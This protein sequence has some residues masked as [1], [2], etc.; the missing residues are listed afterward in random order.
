MKL[1][2]LLFIC[3]SYIFYIECTLGRPGSVSTQELTMYIKKALRQRGSDC[4]LSY[5]KTIKLD[6][7]GLHKYIEAIFYKFSNPNAPFE[8]TIRTTEKKNIMQFYFFCPWF[9]KFDV[10]I[11]KY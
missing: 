3:I 8:C 5:M 4:D 10:T 2:L 11:T 9:N 7:T 1:L 6:N